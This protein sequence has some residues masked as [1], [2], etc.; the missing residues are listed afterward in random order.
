[1]ARHGKRLTPEYNVWARM[2]QRCYNPKDPA[3][4]NYGGRGI[5]VCVEWRDSF[6]AFYADMGPRPSSEHSIDRIDNDGS[7]TPDNCRWASWTE[8]Q[9]NRRDTGIINGRCVS[10][11]AEEAGLNRNTLDAR[12][13]KG[14]SVA[15][16]IT[17]PVVIQRGPPVICNGE[18]TFLPEAIR[19]LGLNRNTVYARL[20]H[21][22]SAQEAIEG[23]RRGHPGF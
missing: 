17:R 12:L 16:A 23:R 18:Q 3:F 20:R 22:W 11:L 19:R 13:R 8:Q 15:D 6:E 14:W 9:R 2:K 10:E 5:G 4:P 1:M 21:G 7:Y